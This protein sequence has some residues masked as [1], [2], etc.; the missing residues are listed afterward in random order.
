MSND[1]R[2][3]RDVQTLVQ[4]L[5]ELNEISTQITNEYVKK[6]K[7]LESGLKECGE[8]RRI[9]KLSNH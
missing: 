4:N 3:N 7:I 5:K 2:K 8:C 1:Q 9:V 6:N